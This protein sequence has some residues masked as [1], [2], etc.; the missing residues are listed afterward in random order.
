LVLPPYQWDTITFVSTKEYGFDKNAWSRIDAALADS[1][2]HNLRRFHFSLSTNT[3][4]TSSMITP[5]TKV[6]MPLASARGI[7]G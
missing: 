5:A 1:R 6:F 7:L 3:G 2:F 4:D